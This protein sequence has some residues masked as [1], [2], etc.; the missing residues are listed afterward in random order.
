MCTKNL[1]V[2]V[3][4]FVRVQILCAR[5]SVR[6]VLC[7]Y[8]FGLLCIFTSSLSSHILI[9]NPFN[10]LSTLAT[11]SLSLSL[12]LSYEHTQIIHLSTTTRS[13]PST[14]SV[15]PLYLPHPPPRATQR[16]I[17]LSHHDYHTHTHSYRT[18]TKLCQAREE[19]NKRNKCSDRSMDLKV[20]DL[21][22]L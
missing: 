1:V 5:M 13:N 2:C 12:S 8:I 17:C 10:W 4:K 21:E 15:S 14:P 16:S 19:S 9:Q 3:C 20:R 22:G 18:Q 7:V 11:S 6:V